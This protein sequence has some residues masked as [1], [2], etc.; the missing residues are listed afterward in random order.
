M[1]STAIVWTPELVRSFFSLVR[2]SPLALSG[3]GRTAGDRLPE[4]LI[5]FFNESGSVLDFGCGAG[6]LVAGLRRRGIDAIGYDPGVPDDP[7][8]FNEMPEGPFDTIIVSEVF[9]HII[10]SEMDGAI[11]SWSK[12]LKPGG[13][14]ILTTPYRENL[15]ESLCLCPNCASQFHRWQHVRSVDLET[16]KSLFET[17]LGWKKIHAGKYDFGNE[18]EIVTAIKRY[19]RYEAVM[20][21]RIRE[22][23]ET[24]FENNLEE[25]DA[26]T[27]I[28][29]ERLAKA[30]KDQVQA[31]MFDGALN[32]AGFD[33]SEG[34]GNVLIYVAERP[35]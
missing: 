19:Q 13:R 34:R 4:T 15:A 27:D 33:H 2:S 11:A 7:Y 31:L 3:F 32:D 14:I 8:L 24:A 29:F 21:D 10:D 20:E 5:P 35:A 6:D 28:P 26:P 12:M 16:M 18:R 25:N 9:E 17:N 22:A 23:M 30:A 1:K